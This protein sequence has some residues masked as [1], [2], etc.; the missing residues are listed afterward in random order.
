MCDIQLVVEQTASYNFCFYIVLLFATCFYV[1]LFH[2]ASC[3]FLLF[4]FP[5]VSTRLINK[6]VQKDKI[7]GGP[8]KLAHFL[9]ALSNCC[10]LQLLHQMFSVSALLLKIYEVKAYKTVCQFFGPPCR[11]I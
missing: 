5:V 11:P 8:K 3:C 7:Q 4:V 6:R 2:S 1:S 9:Y 10:I